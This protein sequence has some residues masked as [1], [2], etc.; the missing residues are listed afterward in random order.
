MM[1]SYPRF[2]SRTGGEPEP[3]PPRWR[4]AARIGAGGTALAAGAILT[5]A[6]RDMLLTG[7]DVG[8]GGIAIVTFAGPVF[9]LVLVAII[10]AAA[11]GI[12]ALL[13]EFWFRRRER[14]EP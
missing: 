8:P 13:A 14:R 12:C 9:I 6:L 4:T 10:G 7:D 1:N 5:L 2:Q 3:G 11:Y